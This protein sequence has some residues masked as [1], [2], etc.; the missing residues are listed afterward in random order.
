MSLEG[1]LKKDKKGEATEMTHLIVSEK[2]ETGSVSSSAGRP[3]CQYTYVL[4][5][6]YMYLC[7]SPLHLS[8][9]FLYI[10]LCIYHRRTIFQGDLIS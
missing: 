7:V 5:C 10:C 8:L 3:A 9:H 4:M 1:S 2:V 6:I